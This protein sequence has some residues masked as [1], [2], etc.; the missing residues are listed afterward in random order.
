MFASIA[1][2]GPGTV[3]APGRPSD[4][5]QDHEG[6]TRPFRNLGKPFEEGGEIQH[7]DAR[8]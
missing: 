6:I 4:E 7:H 8:I 5:I 2:I 3:A 1:N